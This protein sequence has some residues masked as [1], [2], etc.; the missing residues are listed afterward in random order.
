MQ[1][2]DVMTCDIH[3]VA[4][5]ATLKEAASVMRSLDVGA[6]PVC[7][8]NRLVGMITDRDIAIRAVAEGR[9]PNGTTVRDAMTGPL[10]FCHDDE[11][12]TA[13][14]TLMEERQIR[15]LA[16]L[17]RGERL[18]GMVSLGDLATRVQDDRL[19]GEVLGRVS[20]QQNVVSE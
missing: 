9:D 11:E 14:V 15:R 5:G 4:P 12:V 7:E 8:N 17:D 20:E 10:V 13:A 2:K 18:C 1:L 6:L 3:E 19:S 16:V